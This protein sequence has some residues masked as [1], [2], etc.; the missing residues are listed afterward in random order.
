MDEKFTRC[1]SSP[2]MDLLMK[3]DSEKS[4]PGVIG[5]PH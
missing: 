4:E 1:A 5:M 3:V 2:R